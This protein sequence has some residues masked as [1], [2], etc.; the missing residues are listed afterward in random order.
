M[1]LVFTKSFLAKPSGLALCEEGV[2]DFW[3]NRV[4]FLVKVLL[5]GEVFEDSS[6]LFSN[7]EVLKNSRVD[8]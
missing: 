2:V 3:S 7:L 4:G 6:F 8:F 1:I 5:R